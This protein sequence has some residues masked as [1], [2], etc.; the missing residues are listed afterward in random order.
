MLTYLERE[1]YWSASTTFNGLRSQDVV[2]SASV[3]APQ[4]HFRKVTVH[5]VGKS[6]CVLHARARD[7]TGAGAVWG[8]LAQN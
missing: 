3:I 2:D 4:A 7:T 8:T 1:T 6:G 5:V